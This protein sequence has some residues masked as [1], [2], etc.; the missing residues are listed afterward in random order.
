MVLLVLKGAKLNIHDNNRKRPID[1]ICEWSEEAVAKINAIT[2]GKYKFVGPAAVQDNEDKESTEDCI[3]SIA[4][5]IH[6]ERVHMA[7][8]NNVKTK[9]FISCTDGAN[10][11]ES[12]NDGDNI[13]RDENGKLKPFAEVLGM[14][15]KSYN[16]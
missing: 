8:G 13:Y 2:D 6:V 7:G 3:P 5:T 16:R 10:L 11:I 1:Y 4:E 14:F 9:G 12:K 15:K